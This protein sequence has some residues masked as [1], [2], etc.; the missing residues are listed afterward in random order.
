VKQIQ[1]IVTVIDEIDTVPIGRDRQAEQRTGA[2]G[3]PDGLIS[4]IVVPVP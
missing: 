1:S 3:C 4:T 2:F